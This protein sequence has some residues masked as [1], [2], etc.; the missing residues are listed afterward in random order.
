[1]HKSVQSEISRM[2]V[3]SKVPPGSDCITDVEWLSV[4]AGLLP[5]VKTRELMKH[6]AECGHCGPLLK[7]AVETLADDVTP[8]EETLLA[9]LT[10]TRPEWQR[11]MAA[12]LQG[13]AERRQQ[14]PSWW[15]TMFAW[16][17]PTY[18]FVGIAAAVLVAWVGMR[19]LRPPS[20]ERLLAQAYTER[21]TLEVRI[22]GAKFAPM[23]VERSTGGSS[24]DKPPS[25]LRAEVLIGEKLTKRPSDPTWLQAKARADLLDGNYESAI[26]SLQRAL[27]TRPD[28]PQLLTDMASAYFERAEATDRPIDYGNAIE[29][30]GK[31]LARSPDDPVSLFNRAL[32]S[33]RIF[34]YTQAVD[35]WEHYLRIDPSGEWADDARRRLAALQ[36]KLKQHD[37]SQ[38]KPL[39][40]PSEMDRVGVEDAGLHVE[41]DDR[42]EDYLNL[43]I[44]EWLPRAYR[45]PQEDSQRADFKAALRVVSEVSKQKHGDTWLADTLSGASDPSFLPAV[46]QLSQVLKSNEAGDNIAARRY[47]REAE[48]L[49]LAGGNEA[50]ALRARVEYLFAS[51]DAQEGGPCVE[52]ANGLESRLSKNP[53]PWLRIQLHLE[54]GTCY[55]LDGDLGKSRRLYSRAAGEAEA[56]GYRVIYL[57]TQD[58]LAGVLGAIG[59]LPESWARTQHAL[60]RFWSEQYPA[61]R[62]YNLYY[63]LYESSRLSKEAY[64]Q[65]CVWRDGLALTE[66][67]SDNVLRAM[68]HSFMGQAA[69]AVDQTQNAEKEFTRASQLFAAS[70]QI[71]STRIDR[72]E[73]ETRLAEVE[74]SSGRSGQ[75]VVRLQALEPEVA[76]L[77]DNFLA[78]LFYTILGEAEYR[79]NEADKAETML[80]SAILLCELH[81][82]SVTDDKSRLEWA[83]QTASAYRNYV[84]LRFRRGDIEGALEIWEWYRGAA[85]RAGPGMRTNDRLRN[86]RTLISGSSLPEPREVMS[87]RPSLVKQT[88]VSYAVL[89][90]GLAVWI[91]DD[92]GVYANWIDGES[93]DIVAK[94]NRLRSQCSDPTSDESDLRRTSHAL[95]D[96]LVAP[97]EQYLSPD[98][99]LVI[100]LDEG[101]DG[102]PFSALFDTQDRYLTDRWPIVISLGIYYRPDARAY[103]PINADTTALV[104]AVPVAAGANDLE[105]SPL[106]DAVLEGDMVAHS[107]QSVRLLTGKE[108]TT[109]AIH[110]FLPGAAVFHFAGHA[111][112]SSQRTG[113]L[114]YDS[115][116]G[117]SSLSKASVSRLQL[118][119]F[120]ACDTQDG[121]DKGVYD[122][123][124][125]VRVFLRLGVPRVVASRWNV[126]SRV[127]Q[128]FMDLFYRAL[129]S[130]S[131][132]AEA[133]RHAQSVLRD[134]PRL[135]HPYYWS[136]FAAFGN[137]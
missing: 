123:D 132:V 51:H 57:R 53:Y 5:E 68:A 6:V 97:I 36:E 49:F 109:D 136:A 54:E 17:T 114:L 99:T 100:E 77:S 82:Q 137:A 3:P 14:K 81:L 122:S 18:A 87:Q 22:P 45:R 135:G 62:G 79:V 78:I 23:R 90:A 50:G 16:P 44:T 124:S 47:A 42:I 75:A 26:Q 88:V 98:R 76:S 65:M 41:V 55:R 86:S 125:L 94:A 89:P 11:N 31:A 1:M 10:S 126:D 60:S 130:G 69:L 119:V 115:V 92:R 121:S 46:E 64:L 35:D 70:P 61:M 71:K 21:R 110:S 39:L 27:E 91:Y 128:Q 111:T 131:S 58:H 25:L 93:K 129:L 117:A 2:G 56:S 72:I 102:L 63:E 29:S 67:F 33:E 113:L 95:Y 83:Q 106:P 112:N 37:Q 101:L 108:A 30:L 24:L 134:Q 104:A 96:L 34:L 38:A 105:V 12:T 4:A 84:Q 133:I 8:S 32:I 9:S 73:A 40:S 85:L 80:R 28:S 19:T 120:S 127:T 59:D 15:R 7:N 13:S 74:T 118:A 43:A 107:F 48:R 20:A 52:A 66:S 103:L 116:L